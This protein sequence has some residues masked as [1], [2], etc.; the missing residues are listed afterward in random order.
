[1]AVVLLR[2]HVPI[3]WLAGAPSRLFESPAELPPICAPGNVVIVKIEGERQLSA[4][5]WVCDNVYALYRLSTQLRMKDVRKV[6]AQT[7]HLPNVDAASFDVCDESWWDG[8]GHSTYPF[9]DAACSASC[10]SLDMGLCNLEIKEELHP[11][12]SR[13]CVRSQ[14]F[15]AAG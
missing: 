1:M 13:S 9:Q 6:A 15:L 11:L 3:N 2:Y 14:T 12:P 5:E 10:A 4:V 8:V 7:K